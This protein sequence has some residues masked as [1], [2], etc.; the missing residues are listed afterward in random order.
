MAKTKKKLKTKYEYMFFEVIG[1]KPKTKVWGCFNNKTKIQLGVVK[2]HSHW[3]QYCF[4]PVG[5]CVFNDSCIDDII[6]V[7]KQLNKR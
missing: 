5:D 2:W 1:E 7:L 4:F 3:R 6:H